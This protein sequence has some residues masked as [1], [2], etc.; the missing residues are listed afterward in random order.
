MGK[1][2]LLT[3]IELYLIHSEFHNVPDYNRSGNQLVQQHNVHLYMDYCCNNLSTF[4]T[5]LNIMWIIYCTFLFKRLEQWHYLSYSIE[6]VKTIYVKWIKVLF[7]QLNCALSCLNNDHHF[8]L[9][10]E[11]GIVLRSI[12]NYIGIDSR[13]PRHYMRHK[14]TVEN[15][16]NL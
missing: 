14:Y 2:A 15:R 8:K 7:L 1:M 10:Y 6:N 12:L 13:L 16:N 4:K 9:S 5:A 11:I 3:S